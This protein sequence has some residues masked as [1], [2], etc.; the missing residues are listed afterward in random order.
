MNKE[1]YK[2]GDLVRVLYGEDKGHVYVVKGIG[3]NMLGEDIYLYSDVMGKKFNK[4]EPV[5]HLTTKEFIKLVEDN[6]KYIRVRPDGNQVLV[7]DKRDEVIIATISLE[8]EFEINTF[9]I[10]NITKCLFNIITIYA[11]TPLELREEKE[12]LYTL[13]CPLTN[14]YILYINAIKKFKW[15]N[16]GQTFTQKEIDELKKNNNAL[17][18]ALKKEEVIYGN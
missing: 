13:E 17:I 4:L 18:S 6:Y 10:D 5:T 12:K 15:G 9:N 14:E 7:K 2:V 1:Q 16:K 8:Y 11:S 3:C